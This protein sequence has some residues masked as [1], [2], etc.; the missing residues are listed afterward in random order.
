MRHG[1]VTRKKIA[2]EW[3]NVR[4]SN[5]LVQVGVIVTVTHLLFPLFKATL[6]SLTVRLMRIA[7]D[8]SVTPSWDFSASNFLADSGRI[9]FLIFNCTTRCKENLCAF[10]EKPRECEDIGDCVEAGLCAAFTPCSCTAHY[11]TLPW[12][13]TEEDKLSSYCR[14][15]QV[16][17]ISSFSYL[18]DFPS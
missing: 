13:V 8:I 2:K 5:A 16:E 4:T 9:L 3:I 18:R 12:W 15:Q 11:C 7:P 14:T 6:V 10:E 1:S 17:E